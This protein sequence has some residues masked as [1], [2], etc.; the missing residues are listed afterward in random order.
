M[1]PA[2]DGPSNQAAGDRPPMIPRVLVIGR[3]A[4]MWPEGLPESRSG[5][6]YVFAEDAATVRTNLPESDVVFYYGSPRHALR[7]GWTLASRLRWIQVAGVGVD[8][9]LFP[10]LIDSDVTLTNSHGVFESRCPSTSWH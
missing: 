10:D 1:E 3:Q 5:A 8:W 4:G 7:D 6:S 2:T 9:A